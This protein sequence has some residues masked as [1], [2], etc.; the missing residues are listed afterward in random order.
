[1]TTCAAM[2]EWHEQ[3]AAQVRRVH[4]APGVEMVFHGPIPPARQALLEAAGRELAAAVLAGDL[5]ARPAL[6][7]V[8][9]G[10]RGD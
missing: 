9:G 6:A 8:D 5:A 7:D 1:M 10:R 3:R 4:L 2:R